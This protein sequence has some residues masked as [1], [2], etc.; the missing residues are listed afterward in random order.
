VAGSGAICRSLEGHDGQNEDVKPEVIQRCKNNHGWK[1]E[2]Q[3]VTEFERDPLV[4]TPQSH[5]PA[6]TH[7]VCVLL[8]GVINR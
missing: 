4:W 6:V 1:I 7:G 3:L 5:A 2:V 8:C